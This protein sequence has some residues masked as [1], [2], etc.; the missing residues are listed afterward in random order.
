LLQRRST[1][2]FQSSSSSFPL[3]D[4]E[5]SEKLR[6]AG[7]LSWS[8]CAKNSGRSLSMRCSTK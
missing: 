2:L 4:L 7:N 5:F 6:H 1:W 3:S 8:L